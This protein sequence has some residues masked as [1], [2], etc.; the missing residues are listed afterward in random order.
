MDG[1]QKVMWL[2]DSK[3]K[4]YGG[5]GVSPEWKLAVKAKRNVGKI[6]LAGG[7][8][9][10]NVAQAIA[11]VQPWAVDV[12][13]GVESAPGIKDFDKMTNFFEAVNHVAE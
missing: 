10:R 13:S 3:T 8:N 12:A 7:L 9:P 1:Y 11:A 6:I 2:I 4:A 5:S